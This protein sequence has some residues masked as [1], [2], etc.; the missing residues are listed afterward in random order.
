MN[1][2]KELGANIG[3]VDTIQS[4]TSVYEGIASL[5][6]NQVK[7]TVEKTKMFIEGVAAVYQHAKSAYL[8]NLEKSAK[9]T[10]KNKTESISKLKRNGK[11]VYVYLSANEHLYGSLILDVYQDFIADIAKDSQADLVV[12]GDFGK[13]LVQTAALPNKISYFKI[14]DDKPTPAEITKVFE[15]LIGYQRV[16]LH[17]GKMRTL[18]TQVPERFEITGGVDSSQTQQEVKDYIFEPSPEAVMDFFEGE[19]IGALFNQKVFEHQL[20]RFASRMV[21]MDQASQN[22]LV[23]IGGLKKDLSRAKKRVQN[24]KQLDVFAGISLWKEK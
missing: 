21:A 3:A 7:D 6:M 19:I 1:S 22:A 17:Y 14:N 18:L 11:T 2:I 13:A 10:D 8:T 24:T 20:S 16:I 15:V 23:L 9:K 4:I 12:I 5:R